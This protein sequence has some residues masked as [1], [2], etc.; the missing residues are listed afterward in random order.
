MLN[1]GFGAFLQHYVLDLIGAWCFV[2]FEFLDHSANVVPGEYAFCFQWFRVYHGGDDESIRRW[3]KESAS[4][5]FCFGSVFRCH[6]IVTIG[7]F[8]LE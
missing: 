2:W 4:K 7:V 8:G 3:G 6:G 1:E 5:C